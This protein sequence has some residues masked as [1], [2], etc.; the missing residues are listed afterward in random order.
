MR[1]LLQKDLYML[2]EMKKMILI[3]L[4][5]AFLLLITN[6][7]SESFVISY[8]VFVAA[9]MTLSTLT[10]DENSKGIEFLMT[11]PVTRK[12]YVQEKYILGIAMGSGAWILASLAA[13]V[14]MFF[15]GKEFSGEFVVECLVYLPILLIM[16]SLMLPIQFRFGGDKGRIAI[17]AAVAG[18]ILS[19]LLI[20]K[21]LDWTGCTGASQFFETYYRMIFVFC[22]LALLAVFWISY[23]ISVAIMSKKEF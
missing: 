7:G 11:L 9:F 8:V 4:L 23:R 20:F 14:V 5:I 6:T 3:I 1:G 21:A 12:N 16:L 22:I 19:C 15:R 2:S 18:G 17:L 13:A 10:Q